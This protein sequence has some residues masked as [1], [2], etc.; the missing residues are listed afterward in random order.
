M[1]KSPLRRGVVGALFLACG[2]TT[3]APPPACPQDGPATT[4]P[5]TAPP[6]SAAFRVLPEEKSAVTFERMAVLPEPGWNV[7]RGVTFAPD[8]KSIVYLASES[9]NLEM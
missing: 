7:P 8:K 2:C 1:R 3:A 6:E 5:P 4:A 9:G